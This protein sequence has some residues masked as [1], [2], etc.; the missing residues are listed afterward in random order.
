MKEIDYAL[1]LAH[2]LRELP[3]VSIPGIGSFVRVSQK[4]VIDPRTG[5]ITP[6]YYT[7]K[8]EPGTKYLHFTSRFIQDTY[9]YSLQEAELFLKEMG[10][11]VVN[12]LKMPVELE[13]PRLGKLRRIGG[14]YKL[15]LFGDPY[16]RWAVDL[17]VT[18]LRSKTTTTIPL[19]SPQKSP[20]Q[21][22]PRK[23]K[24]V[25]PKASDQLV[26]EVLSDAPKKRKLFIPIL[27]GV[28]VALAIVSAL[29]YFL[30]RSKSTS[31]V[32]EI[33]LSKHTSKS[34]PQDTASQISSSPSKEAEAQPA[35]PSPQSL[36]ERGRVVSKELK[37]ESPPPTTASY[38]IIGAAAPSQAEAQKKA[39]EFR[40]KGFRTQ[41]LPHP[42]KP[43]WYRVSIYQSNSPEAAKRK[44]KELK[45]IYPDVWL[46]K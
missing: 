7:I 25:P 21:E 33:D 42:T 26:G 22:T 11:Y 1:Y 19:A 40:K 37:P 39:Q 6:P 38:H 46:Y 35:P 28:I 4:S 41:L 12:Y 10:R 30:G 24:E 43:G 5:E 2:L 9:G 23:S 16:P 8:H 27:A 32:V 36:R 44:L 20:K 13:L 31:Q 15:E 14:I 18:H 34:I 29:V 3:R 17:E 45:A